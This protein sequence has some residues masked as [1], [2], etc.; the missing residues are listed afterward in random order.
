MQDLAATVGELRGRPVNYDEQQAPPFVVDGWH[1]D[2]RVVV[3]GRE[4]P[5][6]PEPGGVV[7][8]AGAL[9]DAYEFSDPDI[10]RAAFRWP[11]D[12]VG[13][14]ML[15]EAR[16]LLLRFVIGVRITAAHDEVREGADGPERVIGWSYQTLHGHL[17]QGRLTYEVAKNL[18]TG[19][20]EFRIIAYSRQAPIPNPV[21]RTGFRLFG[22]HTQ[23]RFYQ[24]ALV[25]LHRLMQAPPC[26]PAPGPD[27]IVRA[28]SG[29]GAGRFEKWTL[30]FAHPGR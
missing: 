24:H 4:A 22:R 7:E 27:G 10:L 6:E 28:P 14:D 17:E 11:G 29:V 3:L 1:Q 25:R 20:V 21:V 9:V 2:R 8:Q 12:L 15:L 30:P 18:A 23:L 16:F 19:T 26:P 5:G 13:R